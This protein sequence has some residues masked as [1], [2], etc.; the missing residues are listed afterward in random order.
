MNL[1]SNFG[2]D[3]NVARRRVDPKSDESAASIADPFCK[4]SWTG[5]GELSTFFALSDRAAVRVPVL[6]CPTQSARS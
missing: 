5:A 3:L 6:L 4:S 2:G 1:R